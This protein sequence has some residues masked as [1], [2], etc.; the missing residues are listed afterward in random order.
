MSKR[1]TLISGESENKTH[2]RCTQT[3]C[4]HYTQGGCKPCDVCKS[5]P[6]ILKKN[7]DRCFRCENVPGALRWHDPKAQEAMQKELERRAEF[8]DQ[9]VLQAMQA[10]I[11]P[12]RPPEGIIIIK[13]P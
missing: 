8:E 9:L 10:A 13:R 2:R 3:Q 4:A 7:C 1:L 5:E 12:N 6:F 11:T